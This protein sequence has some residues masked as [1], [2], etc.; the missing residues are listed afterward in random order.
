MD[1]L[2]DEII[3]EI[4]EQVIEL[5]DDKFICRYRWIVQICRQLRLLSH[6][7]KKY[8]SSNRSKN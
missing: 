8:I 4:F 7:F 3:G 5:C 6:K 1:R 2:P